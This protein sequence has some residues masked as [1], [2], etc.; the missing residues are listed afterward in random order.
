MPKRKKKS[1]ICGE[2][3]KSQAITL[4]PPNPTFHVTEFIQWLKKRGAI[5]KL[6]ECKKKWES[7]GLNIESIVEELKPYLCIARFRGEKVVKLENKPWADQLMSRHN[8]EVPHHSHWKKLEKIIS[9][10]ETKTKV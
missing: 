3:V 2:P 9:D 10:T 1:L 4:L 8:L 6:K 5:R 7:E